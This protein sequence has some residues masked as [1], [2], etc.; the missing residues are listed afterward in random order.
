V[1]NIKIKINLL[2]FATLISLV[3]I[4][5]LSYISINSLITISICFIFISYV[6][7]ISLIEINELDKNRKKEEI[8]TNI[9]INE[10]EELILDEL[11]IVTKNSANNIF[12]KRVKV[13]SL[14]NKKYSQIAENI[15]ITL[16][17]FQY[18]I[19]NILEYLN[20]YQKNNFTKSLQNNMTEEMKPLVEGINNLNIKIS[21]MLLSSLK[22]GVKLK[23]N[24]DLLK[25]NINQLT[26]NLTIQAATLEETA[27][28]VEEIT[29]SVINNNINVDNMLSNSEKLVKFVNNGYKSAQSSALLMDAINEKTK[30]IEEAIVIIDQIAFQTNILSLNAA[31]EAATAGEAGRGFA[32]VAQ[33]VRNLA[34]RAAEAAK[35]I[36]TLVANASNET[37]K[38]KLASAEMIQEYDILNENIVNTKSLMEDISGSLKEQQKGIEQINKAISQIDFATQQNASMA[39]DTMK[40][41][42][43]NDNMANTMVVETNKTNF[44][45]R[46]EYNSLLKT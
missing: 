28:A 8:Q 45:G 37:N 1:K 31:V 20:A 18:T 16:E 32:V 46:D 3:V 15:N 30:S 29:S 26:N 38:G 22:S 2:Y 36:K 25:V 12:E 21:R 42:I 10:T 34:T 43:E 14:D 33:E 17:N 41:A 24:S 35:E 6:Y 4:S 27:S 13:D 7:I 5:Y 23:E 39:Q 19:N 44:F 9:H 11:L 40:I